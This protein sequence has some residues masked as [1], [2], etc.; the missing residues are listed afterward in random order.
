[1]IDT[2]CAYNT[3][4]ADLLSL[5]LA[6]ANE[7]LQERVDKIK[8]LA[9]RADS[10]GVSAIHQPADLIPLLFA[11]TAYKS[12]AESW[13]AEG[14]WERMSKWLETVSAFPVHGMNLAGIRDLD[15]WIDRLI[16]V[17]HFVTCSSGTGGKPAI[18]TCSQ[19]E[20]DTVAKITVQSMSWA[21]NIKPAGDYR[22][23][24]M[25]G[26][27]KA[28]RAE[29]VRT[30][31][32]QAFSSDDNE[33][34]IP[35]PPI[36]VGQIAGM[37]AMRRKIADGSAMPTEIAAFEQLS[38]S[39]QNALT[40]GL[41]EG[42]SEFINSR[43]QKLFISGMWG[44][45][46]AFAQ[47]VRAKGYS[48][49]DFSPDNI[50][51]VGGGLKGAQLPPD[52]KEFIYETFNLEQRRAYHLYSMQEINTQFPLCTAGRYHVPAWVMLLML[53]ESGE[54]LLESASGEVEGRAAFFD[55]SLDARWGGVI[56]GDKIRA[57]Y[58]KCA[59][60]SHGPTIGQHIERYSDLA[61]GDK[62]ACSGTI[63]AYVRGVV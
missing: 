4:H 29:A 31:L 18:L 16:S 9:N 34:L 11:H 13:L 19:K 35:G 63:D 7:R 21:L 6:A 57:N 38:T 8:L 26:V 24:G 22:M 5:Q 10:S 15:D 2:E 17:G 32:R 62:L 46:Y 59:C 43:G 41:E 12:Y 1:M 53:N 52:Y 45:L 60:G 49:K 47:A 44:T 56:S 58:G 28:A 54:G 3:P 20:L 27:M 55:V 23:M 33:Y 40:Q 36:T 42:V 48:A 61:S 14:K 51:L 37:I 25:G 50:L 39:R 30:A